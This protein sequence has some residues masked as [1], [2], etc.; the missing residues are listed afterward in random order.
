MYLIFH[1]FKKKRLELFIILGKLHVIF[2]LT[3][4]TVVQYQTNALGIA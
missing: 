2:F 4:S 3:Y 1:L